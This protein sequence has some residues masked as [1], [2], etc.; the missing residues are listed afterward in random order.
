M[1]NKPF[2]SERL[3]TLLVDLFQKSNNECVKI[4]I[5]IEAARKT[6]II[7]EE[8]VVKSMT[9]LDYRYET[10]DVVISYLAI[11]KEPEFTVNDKWSRK[12]RQQGKI[13]KIFLSF[14]KHYLEVL[15]LSEPSQKDVEVFVNLFKACLLSNNYEFKLVSGY[16]ILTYYLEENYF[17]P[18]NRGGTLTSSCMRYTHCQD[19]LEFYAKN[20]NCELLIMFDKSI[21]S[22][23]IV[24]RA[25]VWTLNGEKY[26]DRRYYSL[27]FY[28]TAMVNYIKTQYYAYKSNNTYE[29]DYNMSFYKYDQT[30]SDY[31]LRVDVELTFELNFTPRYYPYMDSLKYYDEY[32]RIL[33]NNSDNV[34]DGK[35]LIL[36]ST[37]GA[38]EGSDNVYC[39]QCGHRINIYHAIY[40]NGIGYCCCDCAEYDHFDIPHLCDDIVIVRGGSNHNYYIYENEVKDYAIFHNDVWYAIPGTCLAAHPLVVEYENF[41][42]EEEFELFKETHII[43]NHNYAIKIE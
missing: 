30:I 9:M 7:T 37:D 17:I 42:N 11:G 6:G 20:P 32:S 2:F 34:D 36:N 35:Y 8:H 27:D 31:V 39:E 22:E 24:G 18:V 33:S 38:Y 12:N 40:V 14:I 3:K 19:Y 25:L 28:E 29:D 15:N 23:K 21:S 41:E 43:I 5:A 13:G 26:V 1:A 10:S 4:L 16:D